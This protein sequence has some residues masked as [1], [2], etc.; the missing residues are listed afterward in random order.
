MESARMVMNEY[1]DKRLRVLNMH[2]EE[3]K[4][5]LMVTEK[6][7]INIQFKSIEDETRKIYT[8]RARSNNFVTVQQ[9]SGQ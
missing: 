3:P 9:L 7:K 1:L 2:D 5:C 6:Q 4:I 8:N